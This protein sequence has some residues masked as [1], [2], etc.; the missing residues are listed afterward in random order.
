MSESVNL[1]DLTRFKL[2]ALL[3]LYKKD[4]REIISRVIWLGSYPSK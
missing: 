1:K 2:A 4:R 3:N